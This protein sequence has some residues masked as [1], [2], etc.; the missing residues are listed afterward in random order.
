MRSSMPP[1]EIRGFDH[2]YALTGIPPRRRPVWGCITCATC[3]GRG[4]RNDLLHLDTM[5]CRLAAC[6]ECDGSGWLSADGARHRPDIVL[7]D[8]KAAWTVAIVPAVTAILPM[9]QVTASEDDGMMP[10]YA[11][12][13]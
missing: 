9:Q 4:A 11:Q 7:I 1:V 5:R 6:D 8:G 13:A 2:P 12:A 10:D 3:S